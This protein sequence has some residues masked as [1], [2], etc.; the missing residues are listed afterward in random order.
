MK[1]ETNIPAR[2][3]GTVKVAA[4][5]GTIVF[6]PEGVNLVA[7]V[8]DKADLAFLL[9]LVDFYPADEGDHEVAQA[10]MEEAAAVVPVDGEDDLPD[11]EG[12]ENAAPVEV[13][14][15]PKHKSR[16]K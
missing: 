15:E 16:K 2:K 8:E 13:P 4:P 14:T 9:A 12:D 11:D 3:D 10:L 6:A 5:S 1:I 7:N